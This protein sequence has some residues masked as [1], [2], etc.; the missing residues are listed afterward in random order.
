MY[1]LI[2]LASSFNTSTHSSGCCTSGPHPHKL[3]QKKPKQKG[4]CNLC[5]YSLVMVDTHARESGDSPAAHIPGRKKS[6]SRI[7]ER[8]A[9]IQLKITYKSEP[10]T[11]IILRAHEIGLLTQK[12]ENRWSDVQN[13]GRP[14]NASTH[15]PKRATHP[16]YRFRTGGTPKLERGPGIPAKEQTWS[17][18]MPF[19]VSA[20]H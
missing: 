13:W 1:R 16:I 8:K 4:T 6:A 19:T 11:F 7:P 9:S 3:S 18:A 17:T 12:K 14:T 2:Q 15:R 10:T 20:K 5:S